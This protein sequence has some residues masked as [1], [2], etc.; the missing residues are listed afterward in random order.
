METGYIRYLPL[1]LLIGFLAL[2]GVLVWRGHY[3]I[4]AYIVQV[5]F[6]LFLSTAA[7]MGLYVMSV[8]MLTTWLFP[9]S[10]EFLMFNTLLMHSIG[11]TIGFAI[12]KR[13]VT[14]TGVLKPVEVLSSLVLGFIGAW[15]G[16]VL[17][18]DA[19]FGADFVDNA[20]AVTGSYFGAVILGNAQ[21]IVIGLVRVLQNHEP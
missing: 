17:F 20:S 4:G 8:I 1:F 9:G 12:V 14:A 13:Y 7:A 6:A 2:C 5:A 11:A 18:K 15:V 3:K 21:I 10:G 19:T 16:F